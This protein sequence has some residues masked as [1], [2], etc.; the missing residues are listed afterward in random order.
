MPNKKHTQK[1]GDPARAKIVDSIED[2]V[3]RINKAVL[4]DKQ[5]FSELP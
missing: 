3:I 5:A 2:D 4:G 1:S